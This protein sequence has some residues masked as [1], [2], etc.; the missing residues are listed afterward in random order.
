MAAQAQTQRSLIP[1]IIGLCVI[2]I[3]GF[4]FLSSLNI[5]T[6]TTTQSN[7]EGQCLSTGKNFN[8]RLEAFTLAQAA[9]QYRNANKFNG[10]YGLA[11]YTICYKDGSQQR[12]QS[13]TFPGSNNLTDK[14]YPKN[15]THSEQSAYGWLQSELS[16][17][18]ID[19]SKVSA[20]Y[21]IIFS[22]VIVCDPC[23]EDMKSW[24]CVLR[25][26]ARTQ[27]V[28]LSIWDI[29]LGKG[30]NPAK[31]PAGTGTPVIVNDLER[32]PI[33]FDPCKT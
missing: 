14:T 31:F 24:L 25:D 2:G 13:D 23:R 4:Y 19:E 12:V 9:E 8:A 15:Y 27:H 5:H 1:I 26:K 30:F 10:N 22:Q 3:I 20:I 7:S 32:V 33:S 16:K 21:T 29:A 17:L 18:T 28:S 6:S 11:S